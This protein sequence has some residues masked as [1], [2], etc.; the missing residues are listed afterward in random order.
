[1]LSKKISGRLSWIITLLVPVVGLVAILDLPFYFTR[2]STFIQQYLALFWGLI[3]AL[4]FL[5]I[6]V[7]KGSPREGTPFYDVILSVASICVGL[8]VTLYYPKILFTLGILNMPRIVLGILAVLIVLETTRRLE[9]WPLTIIILCFIA[10]ALFSNYFPGILQTRGVPWRRLAIQLYLGADSLFGTPLK[11]GVTVVFAFVLFGGFLSST[12]GSE[13][14]V[15]IANSFFGRRRGGAAKAAVVASM[16]LGGFSASAVGNVATIGVVT[17]PMMKKAG[18]PAKFAAAVEAV[19]GTGDLIIPPIMGTAAFIMPEFLGVPYATVAIAALVPGIL[20]YLG[21]FMQID[22]RAAKIG[23]KPLAPEEIPALKQVLRKGWYF[24]VPIGLL[25][26]TIFILFMRPDLSALVSIAGLLIVVAFSR[27][28]RQI[29]K[30]NHL[31]RILQG[32]CRFMLEMTVVC[33]AAGLIVG[34][35]TYTGLGQSLAL[36]LTQ[37][38]GGNLLIL[39]ILTAI[40]S[41]ILGMGMPVTPCYILLATTAAPAM[42]QL[43]VSPLLAHLFVYYFG[44]FSFLTPPVCLAVYAAAAI[45]EAPVFST[46]YQAMKLAVAGYLVP[47]FFLFKPGLAL[48]GSPIHIAFSVLEGISATILIAMAVEG[49]FIRPMN[50]LERTGLLIAAFSLFAPGWQTDIVAM[51]IAIPI[52]YIH[53]KRFRRMNIDTYG[54]NEKGTNQS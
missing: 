1:M 20:Y 31:L 49:Y 37:L 27:E 25:I 18:Y 33:A 28:K 15:G 23:L 5:T 7:K 13:F 14:F 42:V 35:V 51:L 34:L 43:G 10:Y 16:L 12:G 30:M 38:S 47:F 8:Y 45:A 24:L 11:M 17:I 46:G 26:Y 48:L 3:S 39:A 22:L 52:L 6:P 2:T 4:I 36:F 19:S 50:L 9:G 54:L 29:F 53:W 40:A 32:S 21:D 44:T 41:T